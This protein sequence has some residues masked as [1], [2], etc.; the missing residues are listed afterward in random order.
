LK[1][2]KREAGRQLLM[3]DDA[4]IKRVGDPRVGVWSNEVTNTG[5]G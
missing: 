3:R 4:G 1:Q 2:S 5:G